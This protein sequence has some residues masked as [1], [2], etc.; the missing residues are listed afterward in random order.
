[1]NDLNHFTANDYQHKIGWLYNYLRQRKPEQVRQLLHWRDHYGLDVGAGCG[2]YAEVMQSMGFQV[3]CVEPNEK[4]IRGYG[5]VKY[6]CGGDKMPFD[7]KQ[8]DFSYAI[9]VLHHSDDPVAVVREMGRVSNK[10]IIGELNRNNILVQGYIK[11]FMPFDDWDEHFSPAWL[12]K[13]VRWAGLSVVSRQMKPLAVV[14]SVF[15]WLVC[16]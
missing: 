14:P 13:V 15:M 6:V 7:D 12:D 2:Q 5:G 4:L 1:M 9:N 8:F 11:L 3:V 10:V 16:V